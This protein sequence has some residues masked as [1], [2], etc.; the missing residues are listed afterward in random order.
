M[1]VS[2]TNLKD[3]R[4]QL[5]LVLSFFPRVDAKLSTVLGIDT[6]MLAVLSASVPPIKNVSGWMAIAPAI[7]AML[8]A[9][10]Y[11]YL[12]WGGFPDVKGGHG[13]IVF[14]SEIAKRREAEFIGQYTAKTSDDLRQDVLGQ[15]WRNSEILTKKFH[16][17]RIAFIC[18]AVGAIPWAASLAIFALAKA[19]VTVTVAHP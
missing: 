11:F 18:M 15:V 9:A 3:A 10:S 13:S 17:L 5:N 8:I 1:S 4:D 2:D 14:F 7:A 19:N 6:A 12:Y 16:C